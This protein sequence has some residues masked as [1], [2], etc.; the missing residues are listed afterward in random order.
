MLSSEQS[1]H[2]YREHEGTKKKSFLK[3][4]HT[5]SLTPIFLLVL[6]KMRT[7][8]FKPDLSEYLCVCVC[9]LVSVCVRLSLS[10]LAGIFWAIHC[11]ASSSVDQRYDV[12]AA[13]ELT[14]GTKKQ[15]PKLIGNVCES[16]WCNVWQNQWLLFRQHPLDEMTM[17]T[18][19][20]ISYLYRFYHSVTFFHTFRSS[21]T[22]ERWKFIWIM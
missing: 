17:L 13:D 16:G 7:P 12:S 6:R 2:I 8:K 18:M 14:M 19:A 4:S 5:G 9:V 15:L 1:S 22:S 11:M 10:C 3:N 20:L 21:F